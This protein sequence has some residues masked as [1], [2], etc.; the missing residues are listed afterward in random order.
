M[1]ERRG[2]LFKTRTRPELF[3]GRVSGVLRIEVRAF[4]PVSRLRPGPLTE[5]LTRRF[6]G[7]LL[8]H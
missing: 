7:S 6:D 2:S 3:V 4:E 8:F 5:K 1:D